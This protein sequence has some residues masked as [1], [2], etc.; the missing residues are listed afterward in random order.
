MQQSRHEAWR[1]PLGAGRDRHFEGRV[2]VSVNE[3]VVRELDWLAAVTSR[4]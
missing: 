1:A 3:T 2:A 4:S